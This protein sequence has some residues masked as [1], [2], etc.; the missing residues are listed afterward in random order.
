MRKNIF[1]IFTFIFLT[2]LTFNVR[3]QEIDKKL[4]KAEKKELKRQE[5][6]TEKKE[7]I[8]LLE[9]KKWIIQIEQFIYK[10]VDGSSQSDPLKNFIGVNG[11]RS[12]NNLEGITQ[13]IYE[14]AVE[15]YEIVEGKEKTQPSVKY[16]FQ[17]SGRGSSLKADLVIVVNNEKMATITMRYDS[18]GKVTLRGRLV[19]W[20]QSHIFKED[21]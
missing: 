9:T 18:G 3:G 2:I 17:G 19:P 12:I 14:G 4:T 21:Y 15:N 1:S 10:N 8:K 13:R 11:D 7:V 6:L 16:H 20:D 5:A